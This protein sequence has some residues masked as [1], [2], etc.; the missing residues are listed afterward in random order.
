MC[1]INKKN[2]NTERARRPGRQTRGD[3][4]GES[5]DSP[6]MPHRGRPAGAIKQ[7]EYQKVITEPCDLDPED[8]NPV[9][10]VCFVLSFAGDIQTNVNRI[11][12]IHYDHDQSHPIFSMNTLALVAHKKSYIQM[13]K[14]ETVIFSL[15]KPTM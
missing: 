12:N 5:N 11:F 1:N 9:L 14:A 3:R 10:F 15:H 6:E 4:K 13:Y 2:D 8:K 7:K